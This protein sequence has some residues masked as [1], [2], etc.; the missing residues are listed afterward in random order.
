MC[1]VHTIHC[2][3]S[4]EEELLRLN[5]NQISLLTWISSCQM[6]YTLR[7]TDRDGYLMLVDIVHY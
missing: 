7:R 1:F 5:V 3:L 6:F 2:E 4:A